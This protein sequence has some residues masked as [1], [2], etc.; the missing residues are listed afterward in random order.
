MNWVC[1]GSNLPFHSIRLRLPQKKYQNRAWS[2]WHSGGRQAGGVAKQQGPS[3]GQE[4]TD[5]RRDGKS[6]P[7]PKSNSC[8]WCHSCRQ[9]SSQSQLP[10]PSA[11][12]K[13]LETRAP[14]RKRE[15][16]DSAGTTGGQGSHLSGNVTWTPSTERLMLFKYCLGYR[17]VQELQSSLQV[18]TSMWGRRGSTA[19]L[20]GRTGS[21]LAQGHS[22]YSQPSFTFPHVNDLYRMPNLHNQRNK[23]NQDY[24]LSKLKGKKSSLP[25]LDQNFVF[26]NS[27]LMLAELGLGSRFWA[28]T[29]ARHTSMSSWQCSPVRAGESGS[30]LLPLLLYPSHLT[31]QTK[32]D[33]DHV[34]RKRR[35]LAA[36]AVSRTGVQES[37]RPHWWPSSSL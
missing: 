37:K 24:N 10:R 13:K 4:S 23:G 30:G 12:N 36:G 2:R 19:G 6:K 35:K 32:P 3:S 9:W 28:N 5:P 18:K 20:W 17:L 33:L 31:K 15:S 25:E 21:F 34:K 27:S 16:W 7:G 11:V 26:P 29:G 8:K 14:S 22:K 1:L